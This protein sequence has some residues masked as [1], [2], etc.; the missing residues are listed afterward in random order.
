LKISDIAY[1]GSGVAKLDG[2]TVFVDKTIPQDR[3]IARIIKKK[4]N[5]A[6]ARILKILEP[7]ADR[8]TA[9][10]RYSGICGGCT[11]Q[12]LKYE[13]QLQYKKKHVIDCIE[14]IGLVKAAV[15]DT[16]ASPLTFGYRNKMEFS[17]SDRRWLTEEQMGQKDIDRTFALGL[18][19]PGTFYKVLDTKACLLQPSCGNRILEDVRSFMKESSMPVYG[20]KS[21]QGFWR[22]LVLRHSV[23]YDQWM[24]NIV[25]ASQNKEAV[26]PL[27]ELLMNKYPSI[28]SVVNNITA[29]KSGVAIGEKEIQLLGFRFLKDKIGPFVFEISANS[30]FQTNTLGAGRLYEIVKAYAGLTGT[31][32]VIDL[33][34]GAGTIPV[35]LSGSAEEI[36]GM[37]ISQGAVA[38]AVRNCKRNGVTNCRFITGDIRESLSEISVSP[39]VMIIDPPRVGM[40]KDVVQQVLGLAPERVVYVSCNPATLA[41]D[42]AMMKEKYK[43]IEVQPVDMFPHTFHVESVAKLVRK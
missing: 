24:I 41:R 5:F 30:F 15:N 23:A 4:K 42:L 6:Q 16:T 27:A 37:E 21:H 39:D 20:L 10:C 13:K 36:I 7:S 19:V 8:I 40:H 9:P 1:G 3:I 32:T 28:V 34:S 2:F 18:H 29:R 33:Y 11:W 14:H 38:D 43:L 35:F 25:T 12:F 26:L 22:F 17:C 31:E